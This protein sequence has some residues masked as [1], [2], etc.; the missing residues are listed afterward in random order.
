MGEDFWDGYQPIQGK[1]LSH[2]QRSVS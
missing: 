2:T 1:K